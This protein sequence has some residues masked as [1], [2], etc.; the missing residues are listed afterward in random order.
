MKITV[1]GAGAMGT[2]F[3]ALL[4]RKNEV[5]II[6]KDP[7]VRSAISR[8]GIRL[9]G[10]TEMTVSPSAINITPEPECLG[11]SDL[12]VIFVKS[13]DT[14]AVMKKIRG[15]LGADTLVLTLQNG[16]GN[17]ENVLKFAGK[18]RAMCGSTSQAATLER[19][20]SARHT[21]CG[22]TVL[23]QTS[24]A[25]K[26]A[27]N[28]SGCGINTRAVKN[29]Q[30]VIWSKLAVN[31]AINPVGAIAGVA[32]GEIIEYKNLREVAS[33]AG[34]EAAAVARAAG[35][36]LM[37]KDFTEKL[38]GT[39]G[40]TAVNINSMLADILAGRRTEIEFINGA[41]VKKAESLGLRSPVNKALCGIVKKYSPRDAAAARG[42]KPCLSK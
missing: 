7:D 33:A 34:L 35:I 38:N 20:G 19:P 21:G 32:N 31:C 18:N 3:A 22:D 26:I 9:S 13:Y 5:S 28:F 2:L 39:C 42:K 6:E 11:S 12:A 17:Y 8:R 23:G 37:F 14:A 41:V 1:V 24:A 4:S 25:D 36:K 30:S 10:L 15:Y 40:A 29:I 27:G 16:L